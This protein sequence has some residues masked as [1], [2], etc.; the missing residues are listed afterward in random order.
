VSPGSRGPVLID[1]GVFGARLTPRGQSLA[2]AYRPILEG[3]P[4][5]ISFITVA[6]LRYGAKLAGWGTARLVRLDHELSRADTVW[7]RPNL[8]ETYATARAWCAKN[9]HGLGGKDHEADRW[10]AA[11]AIWL[12]IPLVAHDAIFADVDG[13]TLLTKLGL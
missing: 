4:A 5:V 10:V 6:E 7:P 12:G 2:S 11:S 3:R 8:T 1:T 13:L 9:G